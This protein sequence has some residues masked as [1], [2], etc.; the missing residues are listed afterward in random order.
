MTSLIM[1]WSPRPLSEADDSF[2]AS[3][4]LRKGFGE[5]SVIVRRVAWAKRVRD[6]A[7]LEA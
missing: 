7:A 4:K 5:R 6:A 3:S 2:W 1:R